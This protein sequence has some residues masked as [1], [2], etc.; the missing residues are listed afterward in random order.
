MNRI[1]DT[2]CR[3]LTRPF[4]SIRVGRG[5]LSCASVAGRVR[6]RHRR[7]A[8]RLVSPERRMEVRHRPNH[9]GDR[10][11]QIY[12]AIFYASQSAQ[13]FV[14]ISPGPETC[15]ERR[16]TTRTLP[17]L[18]SCPEQI[19]CQTIS[20]LHVQGENMFSDTLSFMSALLPGGRAAQ[21]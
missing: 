9:G 3:S 11:L 16:W 2:F 6:I 5:E 15:S 10:L 4:V 14:E 21:K 7:S 8:A 19:S 13:K 17:R 1:S 12:A 18:S 20:H